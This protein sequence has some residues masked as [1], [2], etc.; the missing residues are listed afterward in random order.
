M[1]TPTRAPWSVRDQPWC[2]CL[3]VAARTA[4]TSTIFKRWKDGGFVELKDPAEAAVNFYAFQG[5]K[6]RLTPQMFRCDAN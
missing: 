1:P 6:R 4:P 5:V 2:T 3:E